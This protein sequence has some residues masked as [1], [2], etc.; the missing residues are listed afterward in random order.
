[1]MLS[2][3]WIPCAYYVMCVKSR[4]D[5]D[6]DLNEDLDEDLN[7]DLDEDLNEDINFKENGF[8]ID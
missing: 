7:E 2:A 8:Y 1:M 3:A 5:L 4:E 6:E